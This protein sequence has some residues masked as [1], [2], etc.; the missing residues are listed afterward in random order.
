MD[1]INRKFRKK[2]IS[3]NIYTPDEVKEM[4]KQGISFTYWQDSRKPNQW[5]ID[6]AGFGCKTLDVKGPYGPKGKP[7]TRYLVYFPYTREFSP[8]KKIIDY[9]NYK[10]SKNYYGNSQEDWADKEKRKKRTKEA[11]GLY[12]SIMLQKGRA[13]EEDLNI[14]GRIYRPDQ[15]NPKATFKRLLKNH[16]I[17]M[18]VAEELKKLL[19]DHGVT[20]GE[21]ISNYK[22]ILEQAFSCRQY[23]V[24][25]NV[26]DTFAKMLQMDGGTVPNKPSLNSA[27]EDD[28]L[29][30]LLPKDINPDEIE[31][32]EY[33][34]DRQGSYESEVEADH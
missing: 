4:Q 18:M 34:I 11:I 8:N 17:K 19:S 22:S 13:T 14:I 28:D 2:N 30:A 31:D 3:C 21:V 25:K 29:L 9:N 20:E 24:A 12:A 16:K 23:G 7:S 15:E 1:T 6:D 32:S 33:I 10:G 27:A 5:I 26:N